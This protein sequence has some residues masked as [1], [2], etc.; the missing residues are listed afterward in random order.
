[1]YDI[2]RRVLKK[3][4]L[5]I[6]KGSRMTESAEVEGSPNTSGQFVWVAFREL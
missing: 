6:K 3:H 5:N 1:M 2:K 4:W